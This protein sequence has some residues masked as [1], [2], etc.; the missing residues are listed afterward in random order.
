MLNSR[1]A[2]FVQGVGGAMRKVL[3]AALVAVAL[4]LILAPPS[5]A[6][7]RRGYWRG[8][9]RVFVGIGPGYFYGPY[10]YWYYPPPYYYGYSPYYYTP[11]TIVV[12][13]PPVYVQQQPAPAESAPPAAEAAPPAGFWYYCASAREYYPRV[14]TCPEAWIKVPPRQE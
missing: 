1:D 6:G 14:A 12:Q 11:P 7:G 3:S 2:P 13:E 8:G 4:F 9:T 5:D 10:P